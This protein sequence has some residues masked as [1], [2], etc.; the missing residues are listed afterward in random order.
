VTNCRYMLACLNNSK[1]IV[2]CGTSFGVSTIYFALAVFRNALGRRSD[3][4][5]VLTIEKDGNKVR[6]AKS[7]W[8]EAGPEIGDW[9]IPVEGDILEVLQDDGVLPETIDLL[10]LDGEILFSDKESIG[11]CKLIGAAWTSLAFPALKLLLPRLRDGS[12]VFADKTS[13][14][15]I[16]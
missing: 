2:E 1:S 14:A 15:S 11:I 10:F 8:A 5:G 7:I 9:I 13:M 16:L 12:L 4:F 3:A 6:K